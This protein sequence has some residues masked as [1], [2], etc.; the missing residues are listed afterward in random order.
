M[1]PVPPTLIPIPVQRQHVASE[2]TGRPTIEE[3]TTIPANS[4]RRVADAGVSG[5]G[6]IED[7]TD[8]EERKQKEREYEE[9]M[10][11]E[12]AKREGCVFDS[13]ILFRC[14]RFASFCS[15]EGEETLLCPFSHI[16]SLSS[17]LLFSEQ[18]NDFVLTLRSTEVLE[19][20]QY[21]TGTQVTLTFEYISVFN[22]RQ[23]SKRIAQSMQ[24]IFIGSLLSSR[25]FSFRSFHS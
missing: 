5:A 24:S 16:V 6:R 3:T 25:I 18:L 20:P 17:T 8:R 11:D 22:S 13:L 9:R 15:E 21:Y 19:Q 1:P 2:E 7:V 12:Y 4:G 14:G 23:S 10:E